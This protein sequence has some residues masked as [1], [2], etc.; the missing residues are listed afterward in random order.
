MEQPK[1]ILIV[2]DEENV[3]FT[4]GDTLSR[5]GPE[6]EIVEARSGEEAMARIRETPFALILTDLRMPGMSGLELIQAVVEACPGTTVILLSAYG[7]GA[8]RAEAARLGV[9]RCLDKPLD[10]AEIRQVV[11]QALESTQLPLHQEDV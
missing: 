8:V 2:D 4:L 11:R 10:T 9:Y 6:V 3:R 1:R 5:L 7:D